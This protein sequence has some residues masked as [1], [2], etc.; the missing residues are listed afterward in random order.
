ML[1]VLLQKEQVIINK[2]LNGKK[3]ISI[4]T[5]FLRFSYPIIAIRGWYIQPSL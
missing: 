4:E 2:P 1:H 5:P 3:N